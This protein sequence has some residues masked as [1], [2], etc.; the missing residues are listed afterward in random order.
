[1]NGIKKEQIVADLSR[2]L[3]EPKITI[4]GCGGA[5]NNIVNGLYWSNKNVNT[6]AI[7]TDEAKLQEIE[8]HTK[9]LIGTDVTLAGAPMVFPRWGSTAPSLP[10]A[11]YPR[12]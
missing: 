3:M 10:G 11:P 7:N 9:V 1:M 4:V 5:G 12:S 8:V 6:V 2:S